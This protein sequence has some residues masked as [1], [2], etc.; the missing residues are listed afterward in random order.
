MV[1]SAGNERCRRLVRA[2]TVGAD[3][4]SADPRCL[5]PR[6]RWRAT[7]GRDRPTRH[8]HRVVAAQ[9]ENAFAEARGN[10]GAHCAAHARRSGGRDDAHIVAGSTSAS[11]MTAVPIT[12]CDSACGASPK[13]AQ[14]ARRRSAGSPA[15]TSGVFSDGFQITGSP[16]TSAS[17][18]FQHHTATGKLNARD[19]AA[20]AGRM[21]AS[22]ASRWPGRSD[23]IVKP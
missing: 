4:C 9:F 13:R 21:P 8:D 2:R 20:H 17:A 12:T 3:W 1:F 14:R 22:R 19:Y 23:A 11:P 16:Q 7:P 15:P 6:T 5:P 18:A 10:L